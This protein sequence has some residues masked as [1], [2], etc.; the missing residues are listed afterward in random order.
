MSPGR[1]TTFSLLNTADTLT[2]ISGVGKLLARWWLRALKSRPRLT[3]AATAMGAVIA[4]GG[5]TL[6]QY[7]QEQRRLSAP[8]PTFAEQMQSLDQTQSALDRLS[9]FVEMQRRQMAADQRLLAQLQEQRKSLEPLIAADRRTV[10][11]LLRVQEERA[12]QNASRE[13]WIG[14]GL[15]VVS[16]IIAS[17]FLAL[18]GFLLRRWVLRRSPPEGSASA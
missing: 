2:E 5:I 6:A 9:R 8:P 10:N 7:Q 16:S 12:R 11:A 18:A 13:R 4:A 17:A 1:L 3:I 14:F 15:G